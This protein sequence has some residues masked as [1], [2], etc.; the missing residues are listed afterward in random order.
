MAQKRLVFTSKMPTPYHHGMVHALF[1]AHLHSFDGTIA[2]EEQRPSL[3]TRTRHTN[4]GLEFSGR[5][6]LTKAPKRSF[7]DTKLA[8]ERARRLKTAGNLFVVMRLC[9]PAVC[10]YSDA[11]FEPRSGRKDFLLDCCCCLLLLDAA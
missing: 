5:S 3:E 11:G 8:V 4:D 7:L 2:M 10:S 6:F 1:P 9:S